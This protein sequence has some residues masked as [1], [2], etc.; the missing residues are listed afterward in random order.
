MTTDIFWR[1]EARIRDVPNAYEAFETLCEVVEPDE[2]CVFTLEAGVF[3]VDIQ[4]N[5][6]N[7][8][9][10]VV[11]DAIEQFLVDWGVGGAAFQIGPSERE[12]AVFGATAEDERTA[13]L[14]YANAQLDYWGGVIAQQG[15]AP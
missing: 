15:K 2:W 9:A 6:S 7:H 10:G 13:L 12:F 8:H 3:D 1:G 11:W 5:T 4:M 14:G